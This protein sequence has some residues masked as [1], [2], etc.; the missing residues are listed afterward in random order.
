VYPCVCQ[1]QGVETLDNFNP[2]PQY[3]DLGK[4]LAAVGEWVAATG[5]SILVLSGERGVGKSHLALAARHALGLKG[6]SCLCVTDYQ[7]DQAIR[8]SFDNQITDEIIGGYAKA[9]RLIIDDFGTVARA[10]TMKGLID[11]LFNERWIGARD[12]AAWTLITTNQSGADMTARIQS[13]LE[14]Q[15]RSLVV[16]MDAPDYRKVVR[17][18]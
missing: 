17:G 18:E 6:E 2:N 3:A 5:P 15:T 9:P 7:L 13:R 8:K 10:E 1:Y 4:A 11:A 12:G 16:V 14:D